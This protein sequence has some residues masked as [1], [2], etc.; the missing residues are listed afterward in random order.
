VLINRITL[1]LISALTTQNLFAA[2]VV[3][4]DDDS[5]IEV[6]RVYGTEKPTNS[7]TKLN[8]LIAETPQSVIVISRAQIEDFSL[9]SINELLSFTPG[10]TVESVETDRTYYT[11]RGFD[12]V[13]FQYD[14]VGVPFP[15]GIANG[16]EDS[17]IFEQV[18]VVK[19]AAG[20]VTGLANP[21]ATINYIRKRPTEDFRANAALSLGENKQRRLE[22]DISGSLSGNIRGRVVAVKDKGDSYLDRYSDDNSVFYGIIEAD[23]TDKTLLTVG[24]SITDNNV[25]G[26][27]S[28]ALPLTYTD[29]SLTN[30]DIS[31]ST[32]TDWAFRNTERVS[33]FAHLKQALAQDWDLNIQLSRNEIDMKSDLFYTYG[34]PDKATEVGLIGYANRYHLDEKH[35]I[36]DIFISGQ[37][38]LF[39][40][41][42]EI[43]IGYNYSE[44]DLFGLSAYNYAE[45]FP[46]LTAEWAQGATPSMTFP[47]TDNFTTGHKDDQT[48]KAFYI[49]NRLN[50]SDDFSVIAGLRHM[51]VDRKGYSY[52]VDNN[53]SSKETVP[54]VGAL[55]SVTENAA[56]Y[57]SYSEV[58][59]PQNFVGRDKRAVGVAKGNNQEVGVKYTFNDKMATASLALFKSELDNL[60]EFGETIDGVNI[61]DAVTY[62]SEGLELEVVGSI[63]DNINLSAGLTRLFH[64]K[65]AKGSNIRTYVPRQTLKVAGSYYFDSIPELSLGASLQW[66]SEI[67]RVAGD[68]KVTQ[69]S[70]SVID[71]FAR[72]QLNDNVSLSVNISNLTDD[73]HYTSLSWDQAYYAA[74]REVQASISW[75]Y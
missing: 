33:Y 71:A 52:G 24:A 44:I 73:K 10:V 35:N 50:L 26:S 74:P 36:A 51:N 1:T 34:T 23:L 29:G 68:V 57:G 17:A 64:V 25:D 3:K 6:I 40:R 41:Q 72:Y 69:K 27:L 39:S 58:F 18:E 12:V 8:L 47:D 38:E 19:G 2:D 66:Q 43:V 42:H 61:Y 56:I 53:N 32:A 54:Y 37:Y 21:S 59:T 22:G 20:L 11:A 14:S 28:G 5:D 48:H 13:N 70:Y 9:N 4:N 65:D 7:A 15:S 63:S 31:T 67:Y 55:Y 30:Y 45:G 60:A 49:A 46:V 75:S 62:D 16:H